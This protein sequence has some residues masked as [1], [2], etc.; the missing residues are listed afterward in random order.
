SAPLGRL[1]TPLDAASAIMFLASSSSFI[2]GEVL[3][4]NGG[5]LI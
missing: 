3:R 5:Y 4:V 1:G 2:A